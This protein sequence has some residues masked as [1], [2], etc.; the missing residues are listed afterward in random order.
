MLWSTDTIEY[1]AVEYGAV[2][3]KAVE[4]CSSML[5]CVD[6]HITDLLKRNELYFNQHSFTEFEIFR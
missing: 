2:Q 4:Y 1:G 5:N 3:S 6:F